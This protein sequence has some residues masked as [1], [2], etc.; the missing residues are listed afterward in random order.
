MTKKEMKLLL[1]LPTKLKISKQNEAKKST[2]LRLSFKNVRQQINLV[3]FLTFFSERWR[4]WSIKCK[5]TEKFQLFTK[6]KYFFNVKAKPQLNQPFQY[7]LFNNNQGVRSESD[8]FSYPDMKLWTGS[9]IRYRSQ[10][11]PVTCLKQFFMLSFFLCFVKSILGFRAHRAKLHY[12]MIDKRRKVKSD[13]FSFL[14]YRKFSHLER[15]IHDTIAYNNKNI[16]HSMGLL[17]F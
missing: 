14:W 15:L 9:R 3:Y 5:S 11:L 1:F 10:P 2:D 17:S 6:E 16:K 7:Q 8:R 13:L 4:K 12:F